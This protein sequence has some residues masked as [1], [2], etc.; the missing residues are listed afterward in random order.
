MGEVGEDGVTAACC[1]RV[2]ETGRGKADALD[3]TSGFLGDRRMAGYAGDSVCGRR[4]R[5]SDV[6]SLQITITISSWC[7]FGRSLANQ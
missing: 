3:G 1:F 5:Y 4:N 2:G 6:N 7:R